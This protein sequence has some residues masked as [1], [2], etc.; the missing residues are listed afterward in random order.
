M[1]F[2]NPIKA[3]QNIKSAIQ[4]DHEMRFVCWASL[5]A[6]DFFHSPLNTVIDI[7]G[8]SFAEP[9]REP[10]PLAFSDR[11]YLYSILKAADFSSVNIDTVETNIITKDSAEQNSSLL[12]KIGMGSRAIKEAAPSDDVLAAIKEAFVK[13]GTKRLQNG[14]ISY[15]ATIHLVSAVA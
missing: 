2:E 6:N 7:T 4:T 14:L 8:I 15:D 11:S 10:G 12:M 13:D 1:F 9:G 5:A 3:F